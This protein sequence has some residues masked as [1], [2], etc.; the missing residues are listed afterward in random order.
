MALVTGHNLGMSFGAVDIFE[1]VTVSIPHRARIALVG[2][3]GSG[4]TTLLRLLA[5]RDEPSEGGVTHSKGLRIG[6]LPQEATE[7]LDSNHQLWDEMLTAFVDLLRQEAKVAELAAQLEAAPD[8]DD[9]LERYGAAQLR[10]EQAG[11]YEYDVRI[12]QVLGGLGFDETDFTRPISQL[13]GGQRTRALP[14][15][16]GRIQP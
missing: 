4:K 8:N 3:N 9:L 6:F 1:G 7:F 14:Q 12:R 13:S 10:F 11:G 16:K 2:P 15:W 5:R